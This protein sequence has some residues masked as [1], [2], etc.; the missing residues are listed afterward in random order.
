M[1]TNV[2]F[3][4]AS[5]RGELNGV[6]DLRICRTSTKIA[7]QI[8]ADVVVARIGIGIQKLLRHHNESRRAE[9][10]LKGARLDKGLLYGMELV[11]RP[12]SLDCFYRGAVEKPREGETTRNGLRVHVDCAASAEPLAAAFPRAPE[13]ELLGKHVDNVVIW[14]HLRGNRSAVENKMNRPSCGHV[15]LRSSAPYWP[16]AER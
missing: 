3:P 6:D 9:S 13:I 8:M 11:L 7:G 16:F 5:R 4:G 2:L 14:S 15:N 12:E 10:A 1:P